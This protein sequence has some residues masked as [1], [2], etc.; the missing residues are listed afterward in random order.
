[1]EI[2]L[3]TSDRANVLLINKCLTEASCSLIEINSLSDALNY[4]QQHYPDTILLDLYLRD[5]QNLG[6]FFAIKTAASNTPIIILSTS[7][8]ETQAKVALKVGAQDYL[9]TTE[10]SP[11][12][13][14]KVIYGAIERQH[15]VNQCQKKRQQLAQSALSN[16]ILTKIIKKI[17]NSLDLEIILKTTIEKVNQFLQAENIFIS[18]L[19]SNGQLSLFFESDFFHPTISCKLSSSNKCSIFDLPQNLQVLAKGSIV[20]TNNTPCLKCIKNSTPSLPVCSKL[21]VPIIC[22][23]QFWGFL[24]VKNCS[25][26]R[27]WQQSEIKLL[28]GVVMHLAIAI[29]QAELY[30]QLK[31]ANEKLAQLAVV[32]GLTNIANR[33]KFEQYISSE[34]Q[35]LAREKAPLSLIL[36]DIDYFK[37]YNDTYGHQAGDRTLVAVAQ[38]IAKAVK[39]PAD[40]VARYGGEE[41]AVVLPN[42]TVEGAEYVAKQISLQVQA[43]QIP[44]IMS[45]ID[46]YITLSLG[47]AGLIPS[48]DS[49]Y[50]VLV[51]AADR[52]LYQAKELGRNRV[53]KFTA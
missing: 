10:M 36:C 45:P 35:R 51:A 19:D 22:Q 52:C 1:M 18:K 40:L 42:T 20:A 27:N 33:R 50:S 41:F 9:I 12:T 15:L 37:L 23:Q 11:K 38:G 25:G 26:L 46:I 16:L 8:T 29:Q 28:E 3:I 48:H 31:Q 7:E 47:V 32:D 30:Q 6:V 4:L 14:S 34:W 13:L 2:L 44:H 5:C 49:A 21:L 24:G 39:R 17:H 43:L 53:I